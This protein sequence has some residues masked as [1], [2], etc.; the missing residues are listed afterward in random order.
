MCRFWPNRFRGSTWYRRC[1]CVHDRAE[2]N[3]LVASELPFQAILRPIVLAHARRISLLG[4]RAASPAAAY[5]TRGLEGLRHRAGQPS[6]PATGPSWRGRRRRP[7]DVVGCRTFAVAPR[8]G[9]PGTDLIV[10]RRMI[11]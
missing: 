7:P 1:C 11:E 10:H 6:E 8:L 5:P 2:S 4:R 9:E 3:A